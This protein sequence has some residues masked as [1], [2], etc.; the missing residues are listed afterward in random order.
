[1]P[2]NSLVGEWS[3][4][5]TKEDSQMGHGIN[6]SDRFGEVRTNGKRAWHGIGQEIREGLTAVEAFEE[7]GLGWRTTL[8]PVFADVMVTGADGM[9][10][11]K[12]VELP[13]QRAHLRA[14]N[15]EVL[16][17]VSDKYQP[18]E[19]IDLAAFADSLAGEDAAV[20]VETAGS[21][22][23]G[24]RIFAL[25][26]LPEVVKASAEDV[27]E[28][29]VLVSNGHGGSASFSCY[30]TSVRVVCANT[31]RWS[32]A[33]AARG[34]SFIHFGGSMEERVKL[35]RQA[36]GLA[37]KETARFQE[38]VDALV[39]SNV[40][41][42]R[43]RELAFAIYEKTFGRLDVSL[44]AEARAKLE[45]KRD[46]IV[47]EWLANLDNARQQ[48][49]GARGTAWGFYNAVS[50]WHDHTRGRA[51]G[52]SNSRVSSNLFGVSQ[53]DKLKA[54]RAVLAAV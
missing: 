52:E 4:A 47:G 35:A 25:V 18:L 51:E 30:P 37:R 31:L 3:L 32:E 45:A 44:T 7:I 26:K 6:K 46:G 19:N 12:R 22:H 8:A 10:T 23:S 42:A 14:D 5:N 24:R 34:L 36:L 53:K 17:M 20:T 39:R 33:D 21:L 54:F 9:P 28:Q 29:Y 15:L 2:I 41:V 48:V 38:Q 11:T 27:C 1:M 40:T 16:G 49:K 50:E 43:A 13:E